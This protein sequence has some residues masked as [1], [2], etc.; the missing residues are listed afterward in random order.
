[1]RAIDSYA[2]SISQP[3]FLKSGIQGFGGVYVNHP[4]TPLSFNVTRAHIPTRLVIYKC[5]LTGDMMRRQTVKRPGEVVRV[6]VRDQY[7]TAFLA[8]W[9]LEIGWVSTFFPFVDPVLFSR[10]PIS[11]MVMGFRAAMAISERES[12]CFDSDIYAF[13]AARLGRGNLAL[14]SQ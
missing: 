9:R 5:F 13:S 10:G 1:M 11:Y 3:R 6:L 2:I 12:K 7:R 8:I 4:S 14:R